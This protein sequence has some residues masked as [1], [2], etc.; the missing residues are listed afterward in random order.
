MALQ[1]A[2]MMLVAS[3][4]MLSVTV[5][6]RLSTEGEILEENKPTGNHVYPSNPLQNRMVNRFAFLQ[7]SLSVPDTC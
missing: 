7:L 3:L 5:T 4:F 1:M 6:T 2:Q